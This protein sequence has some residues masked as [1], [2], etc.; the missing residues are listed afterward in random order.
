M[1]TIGYYHRC[2]SQL[3]GAPIVLVIT[4]RSKNRKTGAMAQTWILREHVDPVRATRTGSDR[5][6]CGDCPRRPSTYRRNGIRR[7]YVSVARAPLVVWKAYHRGRYLPL[8]ID[9]PSALR[10]IFQWRHLR[11][12]SYGDPAAIDVDVWDSIIAYGKLS[13][14][15]GYTHQWQTCELSLRDYCN[16]SVDSAEDFAI[17]QSLGWS[18]FRARRPDGPI[19]PGE[20]VCPASKE[21]GHRTTCEQ[22]RACCGTGPNGPHGRVIMEHGFG[23]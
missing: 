23:R 15:T 16:A 17:A 11:I 19:L 14:W 21:S 6:V 8:P 7:C 2:R 12:G 10:E 18:T 5:S 20:I 1:R 13:G 9:D 4:L 3:D 22:C